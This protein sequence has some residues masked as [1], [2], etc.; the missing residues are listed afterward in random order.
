M[1]RE[2]CVVVGWWGGRA[3]KIASGPFQIMKNI[4][5]TIKETADKIA[6]TS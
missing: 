6:S 4:R 5:V 2:F 3:K 1:E